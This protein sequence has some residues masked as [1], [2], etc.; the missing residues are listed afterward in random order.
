MSTRYN[1]LSTMYTLYIHYVSTM[2]PLCIHYVFT[3][4][5]LEGV[6]SWK[7]LIVKLT[8][9][10]LRASTINTILEN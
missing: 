9:V 6:Y 3:M 10:V 7:V 2:Y 5:L 4:Y 1:M 8:N